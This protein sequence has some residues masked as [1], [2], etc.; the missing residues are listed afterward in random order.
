M[1]KMIHNLHKTDGVAMTVF[2]VGIENGQLALTDS[3]GGTSSGAPLLMDH[4]SFLLY[5]DGVECQAIGPVVE[6]QQTAV[7]LP[8]PYVCR[9]VVDVIDCLLDTCLGIHT[10]VGAKALK[11]AV[12]AITREVLAAIKA[13]VFQEVSQSSLTVLFLQTA[14]SLSQVEAGSVL[15]PVIILDVIS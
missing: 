14:H 15:R 8:L 1:F 2:A 10:I 11:V 5:L 12:D 4:A 3:G 6:H 7:E 9:D 13:H